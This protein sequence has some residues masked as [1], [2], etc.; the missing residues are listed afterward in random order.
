MIE[1]L[2]TFYSQKG[3]SNFRK[4]LDKTLQFRAILKDFLTYADKY[5]K[6][7]EEFMKSSSATI[8]NEWSMKMTITNLLK[9]K[10]GSK[11]D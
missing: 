9:S 2:V 1:N 4:K 11:F 10:K 5:G 6:K 8:S 3:F 7:Y